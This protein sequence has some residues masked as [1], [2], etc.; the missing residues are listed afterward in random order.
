MLFCIPF[1]NS[2]IDKAAEILTNRLVTISEKNFNN[3]PPKYPII[4]PKSGRKITVYS[5]YPFNPCMSS[6]LIEPLFL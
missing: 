1:Q 3:E 4:A 2:K 6:T 5:I